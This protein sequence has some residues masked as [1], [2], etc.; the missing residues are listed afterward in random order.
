MS[1][2]FIS[3]V[4]VKVKGKDNDNHNHNNDNDN[5]NDNDKSKGK[6]HLKSC[7]N[8]EL[9]ITDFPVK[10]EGEIAGEVKQRKNKKH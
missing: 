7:E 4:K 10:E 9:N 8:L 5:D 6:G 3:S 1:K 2:A